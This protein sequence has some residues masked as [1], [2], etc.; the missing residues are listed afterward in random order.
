MKN[1]LTRSLT[2]LLYIAV[3]VGAIFGGRLWFWGLT[4]L[5]GVLG[6]NE[7]NRIS[8][9]G[10]ISNTTGLLD[11]LG[12]IFMI[13]AG[14]VIS[15]PETLP[16]FLAGWNL[17]TFLFTYIVY[18]LARFVAQLYVQDGDALA[19]YSH[20]MM[21]QLYVALPMSLLGWLYTLTSPVFVLSVF[22]LIW[23]SDT[24]AFCVG[25]LIGR[26]K[27]FERISPKKSWE[28][29]FGGLLFCLIAATALSCGFPED[30]KGMNLWQM[31]G[32]G[33]VVCVFGTWGDLV[34]SLVKR[35]LGV[36]DSGHLLPGHGGIL[37]RIDS[38]LLVVPAVMGYLLALAVMAF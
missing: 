24:G 26:H 17:S 5:L 31:L 16:G 25:S 15:S 33:A 32:L 1:V 27:L 7:F 10:R 8:N 37:D 9:K 38:L 2:G 23:L 14:S 22:I 19:H 28:G 13:S 18:L 21:G 29:F 4:L 34:E 3:I 36:K 35:T 30:F 12:A 20:S 6:I 11:I